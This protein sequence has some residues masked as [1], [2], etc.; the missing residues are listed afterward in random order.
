MLLLAGHLTHLGAA[1]LVLQLCPQALLLGCKLC[2]HSLQPALQPLLICLVC[3]PFSLTLPLCIGQACAVA[4]D[5]G[6]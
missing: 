3:L 1:L 2:L 5:T 4:A 6:L